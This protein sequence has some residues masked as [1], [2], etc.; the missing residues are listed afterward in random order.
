MRN[1]IRRIRIIGYEGYFRFMY[2]YVLDKV[3]IEF[4]LLIYFMKD[5]LVVLYFM[6]LFFDSLKFF[7]FLYR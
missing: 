2:V 1:K 5:I 6:F 3:R 4:R 7:K